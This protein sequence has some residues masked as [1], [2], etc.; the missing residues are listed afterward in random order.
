MS[1]AG[2]DA[3]RYS[4][5]REGITV[6]LVLQVDEIGLPPVVCAPS[7]SMPSRPAVERRF[8][9]P[10]QRLHDLRCGPPLYAPVQ[11]EAWLG[12][13]EAVHGDDPANPPDYEGTI[14]SAGRACGG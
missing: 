3:A 12:I 8:G 2:R 5:R 1:N 7:L 4:S 6:R 14:I 13:I 11:R 10:R 9:E